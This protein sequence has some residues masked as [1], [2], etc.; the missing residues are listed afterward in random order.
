MGVTDHRPTAQLS[1]QLA[2]GACSRFRK[3]RRHAEHLYN[4]SGCRVLRSEAESRVAV[5][6]LVHEHHA[7][8]CTNS[9][10]QAQ[11]PATVQESVVI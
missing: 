2:I 4:S 7:S 10:P 9:P 1:T 5:Q 11:L 6:P 8:V 3:L